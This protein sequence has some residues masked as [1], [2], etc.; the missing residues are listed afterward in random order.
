M[1]E[2]LREEAFQT[3]G[4]WLV[5]E[6]A[7]VGVAGIDDRNAEFLAHRKVQA[8]L[9][10]KTFGIVSE[11]RR[12]AEQHRLRAAL[13]DESVEL[14][15]VRLELRLLDVIDVLQHNVVPRTTGNHRESGPFADPGIPV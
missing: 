8:M 1:S 2:V 7:D 11:N 9:P 10:L 13:F 15:R 6:V 4:R 3:L 5:A 14:P 12:C